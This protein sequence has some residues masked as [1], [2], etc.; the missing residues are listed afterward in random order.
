MT[1]RRALAFVAVLFI[2]AVAARLA[3]IAVWD[4]P[5]NLLAV[6]PDIEQYQNIAGSIQAGLGPV[7]PDGAIAARV[8][9]YPIFLAL[10]ERL[11][12]SFESAAILQAILN[13]SAVFLLWGI[14]RRLVSERAGIIAAAI[15][16]VYPLQVFCSGLLLTEALS[17]T[18]LAVVFLYLVSLAQRFQWRKAAVVGLGFGLATLLKPSVLLLVFFAW[19]FWLLLRRKAGRGTLEYAACV[20]FF[21]VAMAPWTVRNYA[22]TGSFIPT[23]TM[24]GKSLYEGVGPQADGA[25]CFEKI[26]ENPP[27]EVM[28]NAD[29]VTK[30]RQYRAAAWREIRRDP[31][32]I[33]TLAL[34]KLRRF[35]NPVPN[36]AQFR[37]PLYVAVGIASLLPVIVL[38][39]VGVLR[40]R[41]P[42]AALFLLCPVLYFT[43]LHVI[44]VGSVRYRV[45][46]TP[47]LF[48]LA[49]AAFFPGRRT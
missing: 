21:L 19:P 10:C 17:T 42:F 1:E 18:L 11:F 34:V 22:L 44:L 27:Q 33:A 30:D 14:G 29:P 24:F 2:V 48:V 3:W 39:F 13:A 15:M 8:P 38:A 36:F 46:V 43:L 31:R 49:G 9:V 40:M 45:P 23:T 25:P 35:W 6:F 37:K 32:R 5:E 47:F 12:G 16:A 20:V 7:T 26:N 28:P 41:R 4:P